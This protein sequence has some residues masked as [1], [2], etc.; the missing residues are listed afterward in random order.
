MSVLLDTS[1]FARLLNDEDI[2]HT[3]AK[4]YFEYFLKK[5]ITL[6]VSTISIAEYCVKGKVEE[7]PL[8]NLQIVPLNVDHATKT[9]AFARAIFE[10]NGRSI[11]KLSPRDIIPNDAKLFAQANLDDS[12]T[13]FVTSDS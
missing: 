11:D 2:L 1:F 4:G 6:K 9:G 3:N 13:H 12:I 5:N 7:L 8:E 10:E